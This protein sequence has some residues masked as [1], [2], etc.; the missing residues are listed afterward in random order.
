MLQYVK[1]NVIVCRD[2]NIMTAD[3]CHIWDLREGTE[4]KTKIEL[5][6]F[7]FFF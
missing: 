3:L 7:L 4:G 2:E 1:S 6:M 5:N